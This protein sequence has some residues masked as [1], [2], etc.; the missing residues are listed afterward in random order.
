MNLRQKSARKTE[1]RAAERVVLVAVNFSLDI[2]KNALTWALTHAAQPGDCVKL[3]V[4]ISPHSSSRWMRGFPRFHSDCAVAFGNASSFLGTNLDQK[5]YITDSCTQMILELHRFYDADKINVKVKVITLSQQGMIAAEA[6]KSRTHWVILDKG[7][8]KEAKSCMQELDCNLVVM[9]KHGPK[10]LRLNL[11]GTPMP[12]N[13]SLDQSELHSIGVKKSSDRW[14][15]TQ[16]P[17]VTPVSSPEHSSSF[18]VTDARTSSISSFDLGSSPKL[19]S[20]IDWNSNKDRFKYYHEESDSETDSE[21]LSTPS[22]FVGSKPWEL[23]FLSSGQECWKYARKESLSYNRMLNPVYESLDRRFPASDRVSDLEVPK[24]LLDNLRTNLRKV[25]SLDTKS[26]HD[27]P[28]LCT[29][30]QHKAPVFGTPPKWFT[31]AELEHATDGFSQANFLAEG[32]YGSV[33]RGVLMDGQVVA[34]KQHKAASSQGDREFCSEVEVL[35]CAQHRNVVML[36]GFC[37]EG[38]KRLLVYEFICNGSLDAHLYGQKGDPLDWSARR[39]I[40]VGAARGL[41][42]LHEECRVGCIIHRDMRPNNILLTHDFEPLVG[43][44]G[45]A[46]WQQV[47]DMGFETR[48]IGTFGY[49]SPEYAQSG[50]ITEKADVY[51]FGVVLTELVTGRKAVDINRPKGEQYLAEWARPLLEKCA[52]RE[53]I[54]PVLANGYPEQEVECMLRCAFL[55]IQRDPLLRPRMSQ[56]LRMLE[57]DS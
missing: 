15:V 41:R 24:H 20:D 8:K 42:Y 4:V 55:C 10:V 38:G 3:L 35:S 25:V 33:Y 29:V 19:I 5:D 27:P 21:L 9:K 53:L 39:K 11:I 36:I 32:G 43:D 46:R 17:N 54:D 45:L 37:V 56:V 49:L 40:A 2:P 44:F 26:P 48:V 23:D 57:G 1:L 16:V 7:L 34:I 28:P 47:G 50:H 30:C 13:G 18:T 22:T 31:Y 14:N 52:I 6:K 12:E 51:A